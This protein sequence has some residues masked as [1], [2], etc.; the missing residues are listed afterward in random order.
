MEI[1]RK[2]FL[3]KFLKRLQGYLCQSTEYSQKGTSIFFRIFF[4]RSSLMQCLNSRSFCGIFSIWC[5][6]KLPSILLHCLCA[7]LPL[8]TFLW[9]EIFSYFIHHLSNGLAHLSNSIIYHLCSRSIMRFFTFIGH[10]PLRTLLDTFPQ[11]WQIFDQW[12]EPKTHQR[13]LFLGKW[14]IF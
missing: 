10:R 9:I 12:L 3:N 13:L 2:D 11:S 8:L 1:C 7:S 6:N 14:L 5:R 4:I